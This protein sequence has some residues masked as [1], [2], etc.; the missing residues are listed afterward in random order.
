[1]AT[2]NGNSIKFAGGAASDFNKTA[3]GID[4]NQAGFSATQSISITQSM[5]TVEAK[6]N[7]GEVIGVLVYDKR[8]ELTIEGIANQLGDLDVNQ[9]GESLSGLNG[10]DGSG[11]DSDLNSATIMIT[12]I[13]VELSNED[14]KRF[15]LKGQMY[16]LVTETAS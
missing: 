11:L 16:E 4:A 3:W 10:T 1:M 13:G 5:S 7:Q 9:I 6:N 14:W 12:E 8:A 15:S 2:D